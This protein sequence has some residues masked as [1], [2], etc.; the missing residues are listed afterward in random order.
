MSAPTPVAS[1]W[2]LL[3][4][5]AALYLIW[6]S[7]Y[8]AIRIGVASWPPLLMAAARFLLA[9]AALYAWLRWRGAPAPSARQW[10]HAALIG[11][12]L[13]SMGNGG[14]TLAEQWVASGVA[15]LAVATV[16]LFTLA[17]AQ[18]GGQRGSAREWWG[19]AL[20]L[21]GIVLLNLGANLQASPLGAALLLLA[22]ASWA[23][24]SVWG[25]RLDLPAGAMAPAA[26]MLA[27]GTVLALG[28]LLSGERLQHWPTPEGWLALLYLVVFGSLVA[29]SAYLYLLK[30]V[31]PALA[32]SYAYVNPVVAV[33]LGVAFA[34][35]QI[36]TAEMAAMTVIIAA[37]VWISLPQWRAR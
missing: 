8:L 19:I 23:L 6:G 26:E 35:E 20:G 17:F 22:S 32:T 4:A 9:G 7:T 12:L 21:G 10:R 24:G 18:W 31:R 3:A 30:T 11:T 13:L 16:P 15:A 2:P 28:S 29:F 25:K 37:V 34:G 27:G 33:G 1:R 5:F 36:G 14:V